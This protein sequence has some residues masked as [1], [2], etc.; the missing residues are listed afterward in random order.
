MNSTVFRDFS[1]LMVMG[2]VVMIIWMFPFLNPPAEEDQADP[3]GN[4]IVHITWP[5]GNNDVDLWV[6]G[7]G[8]PRAVGYSN[9]SG[10]VWNLLRDDLGG[11]FD[12]TDLNY[13]NAYSR[14]V[15]R[16]EYIFNVHCYNCNQF[17]IT[18][19]ME[20]SV[21]RE[22]T[23]G[24]TDIVR[25]AVTQLDLVSRGQELTAI[26]FLLSED[27]RMLPG[28]LNHIFRPLRTATKGQRP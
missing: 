11:V 24:K 27:G 16:G 20:V 3:P 4:V 10:V 23:A 5:P 12:F 26:R 25:L 8:E 6:S 15:I 9:K 7:P 28:S 13:E 21:S 19:K 18:V 22:I 14:G 17:P 2:F 1:L